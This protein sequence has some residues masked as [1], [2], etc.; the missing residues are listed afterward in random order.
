[1]KGLATWT[2]FVIF[3]ILNLMDG[4]STFLVVRPD[5]FGR[6]KNPF[7]RFIM[8][9]MGLIPG[10][11]T[12]KSLLI[13]PLTLVALDFIRKDVKSYFLVFSIA[14]L[15][16]GLVVCNN[17]RIYGNMRKRKKRIISEID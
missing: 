17:Y 1:M 10:I 9:K 7:A 15:L 14:D 12:L 13:L 8:K 3:V 6:E 4:H 16:Y 11:I 2:L 5:N